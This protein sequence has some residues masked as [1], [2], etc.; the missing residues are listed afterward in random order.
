MINQW[1]CT[2]P[3]NAQFCQKLD[4]MTFAYTEVREYDGRYISCYAVMFLR[5]YTFDRLEDYCRS[6]YNSIEQIVHD[7]GFAESFRIM[8]ECIFEQTPYDEI[9]HRFHNTFKEAETYVKEMIAV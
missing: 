7:Y 6:Y 5:E 2:D 1:I 4:D 3:D 9:I 8:A